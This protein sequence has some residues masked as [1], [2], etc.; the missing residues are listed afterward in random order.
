MTEELSVGDNQ[1]LSAIEDNIDYYF[2]KTT[3]IQKSYEEAKEFLEDLKL[4]TPYLLWWNDY[5]S[6]HI[7]HIDD[8]KYIET[9]QK[10]LLVPLSGSTRL[11]EILSNNIN[12]KT[13]KFKQF[14]FEKN[15]K[16]IKTLSYDKIKLKQLLEDNQ[17]NIYR[18]KKIINDKIA[19]IKASSEAEKLAQKA[20]ENR[21]A[22]KAEAEKL[23]QK[24]AVFKKQLEAERLE[25]ESKEKQK[26]RLALFALKGMGGKRIRSRKIRKTNKKRTRTSK[27][28][29]TT[30][31]RR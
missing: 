13:I 16:I 24:E 29:K 3:P 8:Y 31:R 23:A 18:K 22:Q 7:L 28:H 14:N 4:F 5:Y 20:E 19:E 15:E 10:M 27:R 6:V 26:E 17:D 12:E 11:I 21:L 1:N 9:G 30:R 2:T 25:R